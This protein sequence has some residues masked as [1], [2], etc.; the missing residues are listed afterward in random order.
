VKYLS[1]KGFVATR[2]RG[3]HVIMK[4]D[5]QLVSIPLHDELDIGTLKGILEDAG[6]EREQFIEEWR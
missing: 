1:K 5:G 2:T 4:N 6:I 3:D